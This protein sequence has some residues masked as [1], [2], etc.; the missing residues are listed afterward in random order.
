MGDSP[1]SRYAPIMHLLSSSRRRL[2]PLYWK[3]TSKSFYWEEVVLSISCSNYAQSLQVFSPQDV[4]IEFAYAPRKQSL[5]SGSGPTGGIRALEQ[6][7]SRDRRAAGRYPVV[8]SG[9]PE[10][11]RWQELKDFGRLSGM[12]V[13]YCD[14]DKTQGGKGFIEYF[15]KEDA[16]HAVRTLDGKCLG[17]SRVRVTNYKGDLFTTR[18]KRRR[19][20]SRS[21]E[22]RTKRSR[23]S[24]EPVQGYSRFK[25]AVDHRYFLDHTSRNKD[26]SEK[27]PRVPVHHHFRQETHLY[28]S[29]DHMWMCSTYSRSVEDQKHLHPVNY[30]NSPPISRISAL[31]MDQ[32]WYRD[33]D[34]AYTEGYSEHPSVHEQI[35]G[36]YRNRNWQEMAGHS[37]YDTRAHSLPDAYIHA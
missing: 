21:Q 26:Y 13:A 11:I 18:S 6:N 29:M 5:L 32:L 9:V 27:S 22:R 36:R 35:S 16:A 24:Y 1:K 23:A 20:R 8:V 33:S 28:P 34:Y 3:P 31:A 15:T 17:G 19:S 14:L 7:S 4:V 37:S 2:H 25:P 10:D 30:D 12:M